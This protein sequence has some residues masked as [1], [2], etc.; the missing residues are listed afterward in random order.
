MTSRATGGSEPLY[1]YDLASETLRQLF[2][3][4]DPCLGDDEPMYS[5][6]GSQVAFIRALGPFAGDR[7]ADCGLWV[8]D[9]ATGAVDQLTSNEACD[10]EYFPRWSPDGSELTYWRWREESGGTTGTAIFVIGADGE[11]ERQLTDWEMFG[12]DPDWSSNGEWIVFGTHPFQAFPPATT[13]TPTESNLYRIR[14]DGSG[15]E[16]LTAFEPATGRAGYPRFTPDGSQILFAVQT[17]D[18]R[19][20]SL[21]PADGGERITLAFSAEEGWFRGPTWQP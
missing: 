16:Q 3:C 9:L 7:P 2:A 18:G 17:P 6:D 10:R 1:E 12:G 14:P 11:D 20:L 19:E 15:T 4:E 21:M 8:G 5:P 13:Q